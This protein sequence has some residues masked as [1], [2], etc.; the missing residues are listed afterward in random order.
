MNTSEPIRLTKLAKRAGCAAKHPPGF[1]LPLLGLLPPITDPNVLVGSS[2]A[3]DAAIYKMS[4]DLALV[5]TTDFFTPIVDGPRDFGRVAAANAL[6]DVYAMGGKPL[7]ALSI[8][9]F[10][11]ALPAAILGEILA[12]AAEIAAEAGIAIV[13]GHTI[14]S[15]EPIFGLAAV[16]T[17]HPNRVLSNAGAK[18]G[19]V[20]VLTKPLGLGIISTAAKN[21]QDAKSAITEAIRV[22]TTLNRVAAEVLTRF[23]VRALTDVTGFG[24]LGHLRNVT[25]ASAVTAEVWADR[26]PVLNAAREYVSAGIAPGGTRANAKFLADWVEYASGVSPEQQLLLCDAQ[27]SGGLLAAVPEAIADDVTRALSAAGTLANAVV[28][29]ITGPGAGRIRVTPGRS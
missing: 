11:D 24:L 27:T 2:T 22:M 26:V 1:L 8:V 15:E 14:K 28:G 9:G 6:S 13:G 19:D 29:K 20:L 23:E 7:S 4:D 25:A 21:D 10:P 3:D 5:L 16:G 18:P 12:G 17:V